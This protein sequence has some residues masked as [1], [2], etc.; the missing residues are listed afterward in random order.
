VAAAPGGRSFG[1]LRSGHDMQRAHAAAI[2]LGCVLVNGVAQC[3][4]APA[5]L[6][7]RRASVLARDPG[8]ASRALVQ[9]E[10]LPSDLVDAVNSTL[11]VLLALQLPAARLVHQIVVA[12]DTHSAI[13]LASAAVLRVDP[14]AEGLRVVPA[15]GIGAPDPLA[16]DLQGATLR[17]RLLSP[18]FGRRAARAVAPVDHWVEDSTPGL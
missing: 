4:L 7:L 18:Q 5:A 14:S 3:R 1:D 6:R 8:D 16:L 13:A 10:L 15:G 12:L 9:L 17:Y 2:T 11:P